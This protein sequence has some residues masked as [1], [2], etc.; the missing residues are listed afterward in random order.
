M[1]SSS[2]SGINAVTFTAMKQ[3]LTQ[4]KGFFFSFE[5]INPFLQNSVSVLFVLNEGCELHDP[6]FLSA[7]SG[8]SASHWAVSDSTDDMFRAVYTNKGHVLQ[9]TM[10][11]FQVFN[12]A[13]VLM[14]RDLRISS[15][16]Y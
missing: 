12:T 7:G 16:S 9:R 4:K 11:I 13:G 3:L 6:F 1:F 5:S 14:Q 2:L 15:S 10:E 8:P